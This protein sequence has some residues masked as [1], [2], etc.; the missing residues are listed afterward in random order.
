MARRLNAATFILVV[1]G[2]TFCGADYYRG[3]GSVNHNYDFTKLFEQNK[4][5]WTY[6][7][8]R[9]GTYTCKREVM[10][11]ITGR[12]LEVQ[13]FYTKNNQTHNYTV[14]GTLSNVQAKGSPLNAIY[15]KDD[16]GDRLN[17][18]LIFASK[19]NSCAVVYVESFN[20]PQYVTFDFLVK[21][22]RVHKGPRP[23]CVKRYNKQ[24]KRRVFHQENRTLYTSECSSQ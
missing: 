11:S 18:E 24:V 3:G 14:N 15:M 12:T 9:N 6:F 20:G 5:I 7:S 17:K 1:S 22:S 10:K 8:S 13:I 23:A 4:S 21:E 19:D 16:T 2:A